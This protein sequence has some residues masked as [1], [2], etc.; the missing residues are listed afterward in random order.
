V[1]TGIGILGMKPLGGG[2]LEDIKL[3]MKFINQYES[4]IPI[5]GIQDKKEL[6][7]D[8]ELI[9]TTGSLDEDD[10]KRIKEI[11]SELGD[12]FCRGCGYCMPCSQEINIS[13]IN[14]IKLFFKQFDYDNVVTPIRDVEVE[15]V[16]DCI[17]CG[18]CIERCPYDLD[19]I[20]MIK[21]NRDYY[22]MRKE[23]G[24]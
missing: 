15:K 9:N 12:K 18:E 3:N 19:I 5:I 20:D 17:E 6:E 21:E 11:K 14:F 7:E 24:K 4:I 1:D 16:E 23:K 8:L 2:R 10:K 13:D 22:L